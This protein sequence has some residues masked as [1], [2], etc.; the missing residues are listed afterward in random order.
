MFL[1]HQEE[2]DENVTPN[3][4]NLAPTSDGKEKPTRPQLD[5]DLLFSSSATSA[6]R[7]QSS[8]MWMANSS[9]AKQTK[10]EPPVPQPRLNAYNPFT[11]NTMSPSPMPRNIDN[12]FTSTRDVIKS[13]RTNLD[14]NKLVEEAFNSNG[15]QTKAQVPWNTTPMHSGNTSMPPPL[16]ARPSSLRTSRTSLQIKRVSTPTNDLLDLSEDIKI[17]EVSLQCLISSGYTHLRCTSYLPFVVQ[18]IFL[19]DVSVLPH[20]SIPYSLSV[21]FA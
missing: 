16:P 2:E 21:T 4:I 13:T 5:L 10:E 19:F 6:T 17:P 14:V 1:I 20:Y 8:H 11:T 9:L 7:S 12:S 15:S 18:S 3:L